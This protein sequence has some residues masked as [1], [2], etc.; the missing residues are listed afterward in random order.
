[1]TQPILAGLKVLDL[2]NVLSGPFA[3]MQLALLGAEV[4]KVENPKGG[5]PARR[6]GPDPELN[7][8]QMGTGFL[9]WNANKKA[10][11][12]NLKSGQ[13][14]ALFQRLAADADVLVENFR[15]GVMDRLGLGYPVLSEANPRLIYCAISGYGATGPDAMNPAYDQIIQGN[16]GCMVLNGDARLNPLRAG[17]PIC[18]TV[19]GLSAAFAVMAALYHRLATGA[20]QFIDISMQASMLPMLGWAASNLLIGHQEPVPMG[21]HNFNNAPSGTFRTQDGSMNIAANEPVQWETLCTELGVPELITDPRFQERDGRR[22]HREE[23]TLLL[24]AKLAQSPTATWVARL[25]AAGVPSGSIFGLERALRQRQ[26]VHRGLLQKTDAPGVGEIEVFGL[27]PLFGQGGGQV[28]TPPPTL[29][30]HNAEVYG[31][32]GLLE[33]DLAELKAAGVI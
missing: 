29:G 15:P 12:L 30:Q 6:Q 27:S 2:T 33:A 25:N 3:S 9:A 26:I 24:E 10:I 32:L 31:R 5:D 20:G 8:K 1:M 18:D 11:S 7:R 22:E 23:L 4:I 21:N 17:F 14:R 13:G 16:S 28:S 19:G